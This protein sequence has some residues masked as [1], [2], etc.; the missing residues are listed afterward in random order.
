MKYLILN[1]ALCLMFMSAKSQQ[2]EISCS[3]CEEAVSNY[4]TAFN[5]K[6]VFR[7]SELKSMKLIVQTCVNQKYKNCLGSKCDNYIDILS[8]NGGGASGPPSYG[9]GS[10]WRLYLS[11]N[12][13]V[14]FPSNVESAKT[15][16]TFLS[17]M[18]EQTVNCE[19]CKEAVNNY[20]SAFNQKMVF[21]SSVFENMKSIVQLCFNQKYKTCLGSKCD[22]FIDI[23]SGG[24][25]GPSSYG[26]DKDWRLK[27]EAVNPNVNFPTSVERVKTLETFLSAMNE[28]MVNCEECKEAINNYYEAFVNKKQIDSDL[29]S[30]LKKKVE[31]CINQKYKTCLGKKYDNYIDLLTGNL[32]VSSCPPSYGPGS[33]WRVKMEKSTNPIIKEVDVVLD[34]KPKE[35]TKPKDSLITNPKFSDNNEFGKLVSKFNNTS[36]YNSIF[37]G[38]IQPYPSNPSESYYQKDYYNNQLIYDG[39]MKKV[40]T[41]TNGNTVYQDLIKHGRGKEYFTN[42]TGYLDGYFLNGKLNGYGEHVSNG[43][44]FSYKGYF[45][46]GERN[47]EGILVMDGLNGTTKYIY[48]G[49][50]SNGKYNGK[51]TL[52]YNFMSYTGSFVND[53]ISGSGVYVY[54]NGSKYVGNSNNG[55]FE[56]YGE[57]FYTNGDIYKGNWISGERNGEGEFYTASSGKIEKGQFEN[58]VLKVNP[59]TVNSYSSSTTNETVKNETHSSVSKVKYNTADKNNYFRLGDLDVY[60]S[61]IGIYNYNGAKAA[62]ESLEGGWRLPTQSELGLLYNNLDKLGN[63]VTEYAIKITMRGYDVASHTDGAVYWGEGG[64]SLCLRKAAVGFGRII[65]NLSDNAKKTYY[66][67]VRPVRLNAK[68]TPQQNNSEGD[69]LITKAFVMSALNDVFST[70]I[71]LSKNSSNSKSSHSSKSSGNSA[72]EKKRCPFCKPSDSKGWWIQDYDAEKKIY[73]NGH[74]IKN[75]GHKPCGSCY[76]TGNCRAYGRCDAYAKSF[77]CGQCHGDRWEEC[78]YCH[79]EG[80]K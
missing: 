40:V 7:P 73:S 22:N 23:L 36:S 64:N 48:E 30:S 1:L 2:T 50:F 26:T 44:G 37:S 24:S 5:Q 54:P 76:G 52:T 77:V 59:T 41:S 17:A 66:Y 18:N 38:Y 79:G 32:G 67:S 74:Y 9:A 14:N 3:E 56:G 25:G 39:Y 72:I 12:P 34:N 21:K 68:A 6:M 20:Y 55:K 75:I 53:Q 65:S 70:A 8:G 16:A 31:L 4:Y 78:S 45:T 11:R 27:G 80:Y 43:N 35:I 28:Q 10:E 57:Y 13:D 71:D 47:G 69:G 63:F 51:G 46:N 15:L 19:E 62:C 58:N 60:P 42:S 33:E 61:D 29:F 49:T